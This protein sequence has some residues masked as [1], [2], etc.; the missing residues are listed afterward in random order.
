MKLLLLLASIFIFTLE[1]F[2]CTTILAGKNASTDGSVLNSH[3]CDG[4]SYRT[5]LKMTPAQNHNP[6]SNCRIYENAAT[7]KDI[8]K[9]RERVAGKI[10]QVPNT[11]SFMNSAYPAMNEHQLA[12]G[13]S[14]FGGRK[15]LRSPQGMIDCPELIRLALERAQTARQAIDV[16]DTLT[17]KYGYNDAGETLTISDAHE[18]WVLEILGVG[19]DAVGAVWAAQR[20]PDDHVGVCANTSRIRQIDLADSAHFRASQNVFSLA[21]QNG[22]WSPKSGK[23]FEFCYA[24]APKTRASMPGRRREWRVLSLLAPSFDLDPNAENFPFSVKP[25]TLVSVADLM[26]IF[27]DTY[28][29]TAFDMT[30]MM[31]VPDKTGKMVKSP[32]ANPFMPY[33][34]M[35]LFK[36]NGGWGAKGERCLARWYCTYVTVLQTRAWLPDVIGG[37]VWFGYD[38]PA[39]T[40]YTPFYAGTLE[41]PASFLIGGHLGF[42]RDCAWWAFNRVSDLAAQRWGDMRVAVDSVRQ[43]LETAAFAAQAD[44]EQKALKYYQKNPRAAREYLTDYSRQFYQKMEAAYWKLG[45]FLWS[46]FTGKF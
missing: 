43:E 5:W 41:L 10:P 29:G 37:V 23:P 19:K 36:I 9:F 28:E 1:S 46:K 35:P 32:Y 2:A 39:M 7:T 14:T 38:N 27:R 11:F 30:K 3:T 15:A 31:L 44:I 33:D 8:K 42:N 13:E 12:F 45:D 20:I 18:V 40:A 22:Y 24:Y 25:D 26:R 16:I 17:A 34:M 4:T 21:E 6:G